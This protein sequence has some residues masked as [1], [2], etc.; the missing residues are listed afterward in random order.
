MMIMTAGKVE[1]K[2]IIARP[3]QQAWG[4]KWRRR[5]RRR[6]KG[7][8]KHISTYPKRSHGAQRKK[9]GRPRENKKRM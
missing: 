8:R 7:K 9:K 2:I 4:R 3:L 6:G 5:R 1:K